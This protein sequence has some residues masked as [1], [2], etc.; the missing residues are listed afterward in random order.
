M[1]T[2]AELDQTIQAQAEIIAALIARIQLLDD[3]QRPSSTSS[4]ESSLSALTAIQTDQQAI[5]RMF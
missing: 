4:I 5:L 3:A 2:T 1:P